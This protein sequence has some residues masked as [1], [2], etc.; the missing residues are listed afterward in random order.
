MSHPAVVS[1]TVTGGVRGD[2]LCS[3]LTTVTSNEIKFFVL[4]MEI[5]NVSKSINFI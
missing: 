3:Q 4:D 5:A 2:D 1:P